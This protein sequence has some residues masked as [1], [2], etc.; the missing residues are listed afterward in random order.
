M[1]E[2]IDYH[3]TDKCN[4][5][6]AACNNFCPFV[7][8]DTK[9]ST[10]EEVKTDFELISKFR[11]NITRISLIGGEP[12]LH[13]L[14]NDIIVEARKYFPNNEI[15]IVSNGLCKEKLINAK[16]VI[17]ENNVFLV[18]TVYPFRDDFKNYYTEISEA[19]EY[20]NIELWDNF[21]EDGIYYFQT[22]MLS[23]NIIANTELAKKCF[24]RECTQYKNGKLYLCGYH[25][26]FKYFKNHFGNEVNIID[27]DICIDLKTCETAEQ[28]EN[29]IHTAVPNICLHC[30]SCNPPGYPFWLMPWQKSNLDISEYVS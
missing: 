28:I 6:C 22:K 30:R 16:D 18:L 24:L 8:N 19:Y 27:D 2:N 29:F 14:F 21:N 4:L 3:L 13:P 25:A 23:N 20:K 1:I 12:A 15:V 5:K 7:P 17:I 11:D 9:F 26:N 10:I